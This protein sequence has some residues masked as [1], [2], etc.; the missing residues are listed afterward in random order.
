MVT[1]DLKNVNGPVDL[2]LEY[3]SPADDT[4]QPFRL[5]LPSAYDGV[6]PLP[7]LI[8][9][10]GSSGT[11]D[12]YFDQESYGV[13]LYKRL[14]D[15]RNMIVLSPH[16]Y[17]LTEFRGIG[18]LDVLCVLD[19]VQD[20]VPVDEERVVLT[21]LSMG[22]TGSSFLCCRYPHLF[23]GGAPIGSCYEAVSYT[24]LTLPTKA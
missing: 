19:F 6:T 10:H 14:A 11:Q 5:F 8:V 24:H 21:G 13:G 9:L 20:R 12:T 2:A 22:G 16:E 3:K 7:L 4:N 23:A 1:Q 18:E 15:E 17:V